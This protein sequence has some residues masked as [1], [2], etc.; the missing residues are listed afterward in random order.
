[1]VTLNLVQCSPEKSSVSFL[2]V[3]TSLG[4]ALTI[5]TPRAKVLRLRKRRRNMKAPL[6]V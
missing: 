4:T 5:V 2:S 1:M 6:I 3:A